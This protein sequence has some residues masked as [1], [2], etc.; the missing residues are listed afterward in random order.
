[1]LDKELTRILDIKEK[2][3]VQLIEAYTEIAKFETY[4]KK[5]IV[6]SVFIQIDKLS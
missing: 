5:L 1:M 3:D 4:K 6:L 2:T